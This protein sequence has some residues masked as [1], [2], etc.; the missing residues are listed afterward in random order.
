MSAISA[1]ICKHRHREQKL[2]CL[3]KQNLVY[4]EF[5]HKC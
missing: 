2:D 5:V 3:K 4:C 1:G